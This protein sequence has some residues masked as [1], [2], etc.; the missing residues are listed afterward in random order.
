[1]SG[2]APGAPTDI[3]V[4]GHG[5]LSELARAF[6]RL[7]EDLNATFQA[8][9]QR[10]QRLDRILH[11]IGDAVII[12]DTESR[13]ERLNPVAETLTGWPRAEAI[14]RPLGERNCF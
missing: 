4:A 12:V 2:Y 10:E 13:V 5:P 9:H 7:S 6:N 8:L 14:G 1:M 11:S 3:R